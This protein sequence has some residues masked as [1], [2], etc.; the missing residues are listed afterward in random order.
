M[1]AEKVDY[2]LYFLIYRVMLSFKNVHLGTQS[3][4][5]SSQQQSGYVIEYYVKLLFLKGMVLLTIYVSFN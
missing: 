4:N 3:Y 2:L 1:Y 5:N